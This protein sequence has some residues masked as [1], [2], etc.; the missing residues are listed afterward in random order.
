V[1]PQE[2]EPT[3]PQG[4]TDTGIPGDIGKAAQDRVHSTQG[5]DDP[6]Q[7]PRG[8]REPPSGQTQGRSG[9]G[10]SEGDQP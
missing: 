7:A 8:P 2:Q 10:T 5:A 1:T 4:D 3:S 9:E 6:G